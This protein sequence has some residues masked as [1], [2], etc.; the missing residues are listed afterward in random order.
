LCNRSAVKI[1]RRRVMTTIRA[2]AR[3]RRFRETG[4]PSHAMKITPGVL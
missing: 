2:V 4:A 3:R 1:R